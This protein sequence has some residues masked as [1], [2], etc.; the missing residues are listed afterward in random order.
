MTSTIVDTTNAV[1]ALR[2]AGLL[3]AAMKALRGMTPATPRYSSTVVRVW[4]EGIKAAQLSARQQTVRAAFAEAITAWT[5]APL[6]PAL[7][8]ARVKAL[9]DRIAASEAAGLTAWARSA[10]K[11]GMAAEDVAWVLDEERRLTRQ[12]V[13]TVRR[14]VVDWQ[15]G[16]QDERRQRAVEAGAAAAAKE[17]R[18]GS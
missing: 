8:R 16:L 18:G 11:A 15:Q 5:A 6:P 2:R 14:E 13:W 10:A 12:A 3:P 7:Q 17:L 9:A 4:H 1:D